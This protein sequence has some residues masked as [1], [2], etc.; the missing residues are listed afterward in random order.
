MNNISLYPENPKA[1]PWNHSVLFNT[2]LWLQGFSVNS[3]VKESP[4]KDFHIYTWRWIV[5]VCFQSASLF[6]SNGNCISYRANVCSQALCKTVHLSSNG[7]KL[8]D[9]P[10][11]SELDSASHDQVHGG[12]VCF[13]CQLSND[14]R[15]CTQ[16]SV[17][18]LLLPEG[19]TDARLHTLWC[20]I[21]FMQM[22]LKSGGILSC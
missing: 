21:I 4:V 6:I 22:K 5:G 8:I 16:I 11:L 17:T 19:R 7:H 12:F 18:P 20:P 2:L 1:P 3:T 9:A 14:R 10:I 13:E 15:P